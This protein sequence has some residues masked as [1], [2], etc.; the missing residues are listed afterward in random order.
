MIGITRYT[1][2]DVTIWDAFVDQ[3]KNGTFLLKRNYMDYHADRFRDHSLIVRN[4]KGH[5]LA[6]LP[7]DEHGDVLRSHGGLTYGGLITHDTMTTPW[8][9]EIFAAVAQYGRARG[10]VR[11]EY[12]AVPSIYHRLPS[13]EDRYALFLSDARM[14]RRDVLSVVTQANRLPY[15][16]RR[17]RK[18]AQARKQQLSVRETDDIAQYWSMLEESL[19]NTHDVAPVHSLAEITLLRER[20]RDEIKLYGCFDAEGEMLAGVVMYFSA[21]VAHVQYICSGLRGKELG[22]LD[23]LFAELLDNVCQQYPYFDFGIS[24]EDRGRHLNVGLIEQKE[25]FGARAIAQDFYE[26]T[27]T[28]IA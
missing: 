28:E 25:G 1:Q 23:L 14:V 18:I 27:L 11:I 8:M 10:F 4:A 19:R 26:L 17:R 5:I 13:D 15:Q 3:S 16:E 6:V 20:F 7:A 12:K 2:D 22:A 21:Q 24:T 9:L